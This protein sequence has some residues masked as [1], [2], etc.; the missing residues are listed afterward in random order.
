M[1]KHLFPFGVDPF[2][3]GDWC[4]GKQTESKTMLSP[5]SKMVE[6]PGR[7]STIFEGYIPLKTKYKI[8]YVNKLLWL[9]KFITKTCLYNFDPLKPLSYIV[10]LGFTRV[11]II[12][13]ISTQ[14][15]DCGYSLEPPIYVLSRNMKN[16]GVF[17]SENFQFLVVKFSIYLNRHVFIMQ[18]L[19]EFGRRVTQR[20]VRVDV[21]VLTV[22]N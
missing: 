1:R 6:T 22:K 21:W 20:Q 3:E 7:F 18:Q 2:L 13:L 5:L 14:N 19:F 9:V 8:Y 4:A 12:F 17:L 16:I 15:I 11:Y 10:K